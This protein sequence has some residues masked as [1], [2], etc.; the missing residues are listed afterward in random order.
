MC[1]NTEFPRTSALSQANTLFSLTG[2]FV[3]IFGPFGRVA[4]RNLNGETY[5]CIYN[6]AESSEAKA[7]EIIC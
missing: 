2:G 5:V 3:P 4:V 6:F 1:C 7:R